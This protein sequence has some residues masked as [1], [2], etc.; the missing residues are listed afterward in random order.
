[1]IKRAGFT[2][3]SGNF[4]RD[5]VRA[6]G[7]RDEDRLVAYLESSTEIYSVMGAERD[8]V[9][10]DTWIPGAGS[11]VTDG[12]WLW[13]AELAHYVRRHHVLLPADFVAHI[14]DNGYVCPAL[15]EERARAIFDEHFGRDGATGADARDATPE[16]FFLWYVPRLTRAASLTLIKQLGAAGLSVVHPLTDALFGSRETSDGGRAP[17]LGGPDVLADSLADDRYHEVEFQCWMGYDRPVPARVRRLAP[18]VQRVT[19]RIADVPESE[20]EEA[21][22]ALVRTLDRYGPLAVFHRAER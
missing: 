12:T 10:G 21:V 11:L 13:P 5:A 2:G 1:M 3:K 16:P 14:R 6:V 7:E 17:L 15:P 19:V 4:L 9:T 20:R 22:A 18:S 8:V